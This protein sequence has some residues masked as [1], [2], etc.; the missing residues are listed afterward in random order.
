MKLVQKFPDYEFRTTVVPVIRE[1]KID[2]IKKEDYEKMAEW[3]VEVTG[4]NR[5]KHYLQRFVARGEN[6][7]IDKKFSKENLDAEFHETPKKL[8][9]EI[10]EAVVKYLVNCE[11]R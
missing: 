7:M 9:E 5:H 10:H 8:I 4:E 3:I 11:V 1:D 2:W 6:E